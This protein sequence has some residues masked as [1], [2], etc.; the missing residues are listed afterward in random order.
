MTTQV[1]RARTLVEARQQATQV[2]G[3]GA[4]IL[5]TREVK[6]AGIGGILGGTD[7]EVAAAVLGPATEMHARLS[8]RPFSPSAY[9]PA[10]EAARPKATMEE[11][12]I[13]SSLRAE[14][15][16]EMRAMKLAL[17]RNTA[18]HADLAVEL[19]A[20]REMLDQMTPSNRGD[21][22]AKLVA[23]RGIEGAAATVVLRAMRAMPEGT[24]SDRLRATLATLLEVSPWPLSAKGRTLIAAVGPTGVG[25]TTTLAKLAT[26]A[27]IDKKSVMLVTCDTFRV[28]GVEQIKRYASLLD[29]RH[30]VAR[31]AKGLAAV[32]A[33]SESDVIL[34]D[35]SGRPFRADSAEGLLTPERFA[36][37]DGSGGISRHVLLCMPA[38]V[39]WVD[40]VRT[41]KSFAAAKPVAIAVTK[42]D[43]TDTPS[44]L[45]HAALAS[46]LPLSLLCTGPRV[47]E[48]IEGA[49][50]VGL[51]ERILGSS[52]KDGKAR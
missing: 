36:S 42:T 34:I 32:I 50:S 21:K 20:I 26:R 29:V 35:T 25:K 3:K 30:E 9:A 18:P 48:D 6:R 16:G 39:R 28:G 23:A 33:S 22:L 7:V 8:P 40:A 27:K 31:D 43:E 15:H 52:S 45:V 49:T 51:V 2:L 14:V 46:K 47:P 41:V 13:L 19:V 24:A 17:A 10:P 4:V 5:T 1:F 44:G 38:S 37:L 11:R 12:E